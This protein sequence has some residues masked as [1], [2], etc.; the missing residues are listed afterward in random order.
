MSS[1]AT[2]PCLCASAASSAVASASCRRRRGT[3]TCSFSTPTNDSAC[4]HPIITCPAPGQR[5]RASSTPRCM[6]L[7][8]YDTNLACSGGPSGGRVVS[9]TPYAPAPL[10]NG[11]TTGDTYPAVSSRG[12][13]GAISCAVHSCIANNAGRGAV[14]WSG[15]ACSIGAA[16][17]KDAYDAAGAAETGAP[18]PGDVAPHFARLA[19]AKAAARARRTCASCV[20]AGCK[21]AG[22]EET[23]WPSE[24]SSRR[25]NVAVSPSP[26][27]S[28]PLSIRSITTGA[29]AL[30]RDSPLTDSVL[31]KAAHGRDGDAC[32][33]GWRDGAALSSSMWTVEGAGSNLACDA[34]AVVALSAKALAPEVHAYRSTA[35]VFRGSAAA[36]RA[37]DGGNI[38]VGRLA[39]AADASER[40]SARASCIS[41]SSSTP[42]SSP[43]L[44][45]PPPLTLPSP[46]SCAEPI[47][48]A[49]GAS[50]AV[51]AASTPLAPHES[52]PSST[53]S[54]PSA[55]GGTLAPPP[56]L[57]ESPQ[58]V[59]FD[60]PIARGGDARTSRPKLQRP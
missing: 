14:P 12:I 23:P 45:K 6:S 19:A 9:A 11:C 36:K 13:N 31:R 55:F 16:S 18:P 40:E 29:A 30:P 15:Q 39:D 38:C 51:H 37:G 22:C 52:W 42:S 34:A 25:S 21:D 1:A 35:S 47:T 41:S 28:S 48:T 46:L 59:L 7:S 53:S 10:P 8:L 32:R 43:S 54:E 3:T 50:T 49:I 5:T 24:E 2:Q 4:V 44:Q 57:L 56:P 20:D 58:Q 17:V 27:T 26:R 60:A 33:A